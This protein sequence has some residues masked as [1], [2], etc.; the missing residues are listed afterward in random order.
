M[1]RWFAE[2]G[3][4]L[5]SELEVTPVGTEVWTW[6]DSDRSAGFVARRCAHELAVHRFDAQSARGTPDPIPSELAV[7]GIAEILDVLV[8]ARDRTGTATA[9]TM[10]LHGTDADNAEWLA[11]LLPD[12]IDVTRDHAKADLALRGAVSDLELILYRRPT[13]GTVELFGDQS[14]LD[15]WYAEFEF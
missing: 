1:A 4:Q 5:V 8:S 15:A 13:L 11:T 12:R 9:Q 6:F 3:A 7:D 14:V 10:H 2:I